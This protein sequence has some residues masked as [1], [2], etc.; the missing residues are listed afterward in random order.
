MLNF[1]ELYL[2]CNKTVTFRFEADIIAV[3]YLSFVIFFMTII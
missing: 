3:L 1:A 2:H